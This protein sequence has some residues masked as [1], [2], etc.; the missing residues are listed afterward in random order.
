MNEFQII[1][2][3][4]QFS[5]LDMALVMAI[6]SDFDTKEEAQEMLQSL[7]ETM[8]TDQLSL[9]AGLAAAENEGG[10]SDISETSSGVDSLAQSVHTSDGWASPIQHKT[11]LTDPSDF[12]QLCVSNSDTTRE[13]TSDSKETSQQ[14]PQTVAVPVSSPQKRPHK[15]PKE[16]PKKPLKPPQ[17][18]STE[19]AFE[20]SP[21][22]RHEEVNFDDLDHFTN[23]TNETYQLANL[24]PN[25][26]CLA[27][28]D[29]FEVDIGRISNL[30]SVPR[31]NV[32]KYYHI[33]NASISKAILDIIQDATVPAPG[34][35][36]LE[37]VH[38]SL[39]DFPTIPFM[40]LERLYLV[41]QDEA[42]YY[43]IAQVIADYDKWNE[44][45]K[46][47]KGDSYAK[48]ISNETNSTDG[49][50]LV[51]NKASVSIIKSVS[52]LTTQRDLFEN[53]HGDFK[54]KYMNTT[55]PGLKQQYKA[56]MDEVMGKKKGVDARIKF[57]YYTKTQAA[58]FTDLH[59]MAVKEALG[60]VAAKIEDWWELEK[61]FVLKD[62][63]TK[64]LKLVTGAGNHSKGG[65]PK[66]KLSLIR[67]LKL[68]GWQY[69]ATSGY[70][71]V[72]GKRT[73]KGV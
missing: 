14:Q 65:V 12:G 47:Q 25:E 17:T 21:T 54:Q 11:L 2:L 51:G 60:V 68:N 50:T 28:W 6:A 62:E 27:Q 66:I 16:S 58:Y 43:A 22:H 30:L 32:A 19:E 49:F 29:Q 24:R 36:V 59:G 7:T 70:I 26:E 3:C 4:A 33:A 46:S 67:W 42:K 38:N 73:V 13:T 69:E 55:D 40:Y 45:G 57:L 56:S 61:V 10:D 37:F 48:R 71:L 52:E 31:E 72:K 18:P 34:P 53:M 15:S 39:L 20:S 41:V 9:N 1:A 8:E 64:P 5:K 35:E 44:L 23:A 63:E